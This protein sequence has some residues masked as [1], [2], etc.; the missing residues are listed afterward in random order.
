YKEIN[1]E[2]ELE[3]PNSIINYYKELINLRKKSDVLIYGNYEL[4]LEEHDQIFAYKRVLNGET[5]VVL[6]NLFDQ[7]VEMELPDD[8]AGKR[9]ELRLSNYQM[10]SVVETLG[11]TALR[12]YEARV[13]QVLLGS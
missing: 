3:N 11:K 2:E 9:A 8:L 12:P 10:E 7:E 4:I 6:T 5:Y 13:Y 1:V